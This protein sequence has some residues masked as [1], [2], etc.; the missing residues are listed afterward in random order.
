M[1]AGMCG[2]YKLNWGHF[3]ASDPSNTCAMLFRITIFSVF[4]ICILVASWSPR[5]DYSNKSI[6]PTVI[7]GWGDWGTVEWCPHGTIAH[8]IALKVE[9]FQGGGRREDDTAL[10]GIQLYCRWPSNNTN[11]NDSHDRSKSAPKSNTVESCK[12]CCPHLAVKLFGSSV[13]LQFLKLSDSDPSNV[14]LPICTSRYQSAIWL[15]LHHIC[16]HC[17]DPQVGNRDHKT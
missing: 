12:L 4:L 14:L 5:T 13:L 10:N 7:A 16:S 15:F 9:G 1:H 6:R 2:W 11:Y 17:I 8:G 3:S